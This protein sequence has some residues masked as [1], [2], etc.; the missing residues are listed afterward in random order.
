MFRQNS[1]IILASKTLVRKPLSDSKGR[2]TVP[3]QRSWNNFLPSAHWSRKGRREQS[4]P[5]RVGKQDIN[6]NK[7]DAKFLILRGPSLFFRA[8]PGSEFYI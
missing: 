4:S 5:S 8:Y 7:S 1:F 3:Q 2:K 6:E